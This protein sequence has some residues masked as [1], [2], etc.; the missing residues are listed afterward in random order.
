MTLFLILSISSCL[1]TVETKYII[2]RPPL[3]L[4]DKRE[5]PLFIGSTV[6]DLKLYTL[7]LVKVITLS[8]ED[9]KKIEEWYDLM[10]QELNSKDGQ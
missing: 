8:N 4:V 3:E 10:E 6:D 1:T 9:K 2:K 7:D 5:V